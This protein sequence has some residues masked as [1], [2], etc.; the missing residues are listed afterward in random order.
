[1]P[2]R[3]HPL[4]LSSF[5]PLPLPIPLPI[6]LHLPPPLSL[7]PLPI[8]VSPPLPHFL[9][10][11]Q[12]PSW[13]EEMIQYGTW[14]D[15]FYQLAEQ[16]PDCLMLKFT[17]KLISDAGFQSE[18]TSASTASHQPEVYSSLVR[19]ALTQIIASHPTKARESLADF[20]VS[21]NQALPG[22]Y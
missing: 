6:H 8:S 21:E 13:L 18:I 19:N 10:L 15:L 1:M 17:I 3:I 2:F 5:L 16:Y 7:L 22:I 4:P 14:R 9:S 12:T 11:P 20:T